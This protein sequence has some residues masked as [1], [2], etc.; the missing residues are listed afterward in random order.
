M[1]MSSSYSA[2]LVIS[3]LFGAL[4][5]F[6]IGAVFYVFHSLGLYRIMKNRGFENPWMAW[7]PV[8]NYYAFGK[9][10]D[11]I[12]LRTRGKNTHLRLWLLWLGLAAM[13]SSL[14]YLTVYFACFFPM[15]QFATPPSDMVAGM[16]FIILLFYGVLLAVS[17]A[18]T[19]FYGIAIYRLFSDYHPQNAVM[20]TVLSLV[21][22]I[23][24]P[25]LIFSV[26]NRQPVS[27]FRQPVQG[28]YG[29]PPQY[30]PYYPQTPGVPPQNGGGSPD[31]RA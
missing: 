23:V 25:F 24:G 5:G 10:S 8:A 7:V 26:R 17:I 31:S 2:I 3:I 15:L 29:M 30:T 9:V 6:A 13:I 12:N 4:I 21:F 20:Y 14:S 1:S 19:V 11:D 27:L 22:N 28:P 18:Y 16:V